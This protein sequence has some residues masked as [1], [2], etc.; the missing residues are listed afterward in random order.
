MGRGP[1]VV[2][3]YL[4][5]DMVVVRLAGMLTNAERHLVG[6]LPAAEGRDLLK[7]VRSQIL[8]AARPILESMIED[9]TGIKVVSLHHDISTTT[10][11]KDFSARE[12]QKTRLILA[13]LGPA[14]LQQGSRVVDTIL[15]RDG[16]GNPRSVVIW[17]PIV[18]RIRPGVGFNGKV[19]LIAQFPH[20]ARNTFCHDFGQALGQNSPETPVAG[21]DNS[22][23]RNFPHFR[24][25]VEIVNS[26]CIE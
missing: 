17:V 16:S 21:C 15:A 14:K 8:E 25:P 20:L 7:Q 6:S 18:R 24:R 5:G 3:T 19:V 13:S 26:R 9:I 1:K 22:I 11:E 10:G 12:T 4:V 2:N 23:G